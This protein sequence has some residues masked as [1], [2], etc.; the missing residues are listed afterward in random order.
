V[1]LPLH[2]R[3]AIGVELSK[4]YRDIP[5]EPVFQGDSL[6]FDDSVVILKLYTSLKHEYTGYGNLFEQVNDTRCCSHRKSS[7]NEDLNNS[8]HM[9]C[10]VTTTKKACLDQS[11]GAPTENFFS[12]SSSR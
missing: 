7:V 9:I 8:D 12:F 11:L 3:R 2:Q 6:S 4:A 5:G 10:Y 1:H